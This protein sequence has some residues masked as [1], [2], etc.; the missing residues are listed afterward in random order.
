MDDVAKAVLYTFSHKDE[1]KG[2]RKLEIA[3]RARFEPPL[4]T[5]EN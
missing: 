1:I 4:F 3:G 2:L 5:L